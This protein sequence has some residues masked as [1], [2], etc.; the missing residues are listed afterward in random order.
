MDPIQDIKELYQGDVVHHPALGFAVVDQVEKGAAHLAWESNGARLPPLVSMDLLA[1][2]YRR[3]VPG[4]FLY[5]SV[6]EKPSLRLLIDDQPVEALRLLLDDLGERQGRAE[7]RDW[8]TGRDI[9]ST[10][11][12]DRWWTSLEE[13]PD[14]GALQ[15]SNDRRKVGLMDTEIPTDPEAFLGSPPRGR[16]RI[17]GSA[18][19]E[20]RIRLLHQAI[21]ARDSDAILLLMRV[22][23][24]LP[25]DAMAALRKLARN[26][27]HGVT[28]AL[29]DRQDQ[30]MIRTMVGPASRPNTQDRVLSALGRLPP[31][32]RA[33]VAVS[34]IEE[35]LTME[36]E[37]PAAE[38][39]CSTITGGTTK[40]L[41]TAS[42]LNEAHN[43]M[44]WLQKRVDDD[45]LLG[46]PT[47]L[48]TRDTIEYSANHAPTPSAQ[49]IANL[50]DIAAD[51]IFPVSIGIAKALSARH[52]KGETGG[53]PG[54][55]I[56]V[57]SLVELGPTEPRT[58]RDDV[59]DAMRLVLEAV[60][61][62]LP[63]DAH[64][65]DGDLLPHINQLRSDLPVEWIAV[66]MQ[67]LAQDVDSRPSNGTSLWTRLA[68][69]YASQTVRDL[70]PATHQNIAIAHDTHIGIAK[71]RRMQTNQDAAFYAQA[72]R[73]SIM[74]VAD[75]ISVST[76]GSGNLASALLVQSVA[77]Q[78]ESDSTKIAK[79]KPQEIMAWLEQSL[80]RGNESICTNS[81]QLAQGD[82][83]QQIP[84]GT[85]A[86]LAI[87]R[88]SVLYVASLGDSRAYLVT[89]S[90]VSLL[91][92]DQN[93]RGLWLCAHKSGSALPNVADEGFALVGYCGRFDQNTKPSPADPVTRIVNLLETDTLLL[94][95][96]GLTDYAAGTIDGQ[97]E[98]VAKS[99]AF[100]DLNKGC[101]Y[102]IERANEGGGGDNITVM[103]ARIAND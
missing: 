87:I 102:L 26:G 92:G 21:V 95:S 44:T 29:L 80:I 4:G 66:C 84:M 78:W 101:R 41:E 6:I 98:V 30:Q 19:T 55:R 45:K 63:A 94:C 79:M 39:L 81:M 3:C 48:S 100:N 36:G 57:A 74:L 97:S 23:K 43:A 90:G 27:D 22:Q 15:W 72:G 16:W 38:W 12:F 58:P 35:A 103:L 42:V 60:V 14:V 18:D 64:L 20:A 47:L 2:G 76:A 1:K 70:A 54:A 69:A 85:T 89:D 32:R 11:E 8:M 25:P 28:A 56:D 68:R 65:N 83:S 24:E 34:I 91:T 71:S 52:G 50:R 62:P 33:Q 7:I 99:A 51:R 13:A 73:V 67:S 61:G 17:A 75:G 53:I 40:L 5:R 88:D 86:V 93:V 96:D 37:P 82:L 31:T 46:E 9:M 49:L 10:A 59:R 77:G